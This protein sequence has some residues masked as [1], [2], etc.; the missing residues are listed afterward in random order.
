[1]EEATAT[2]QKAAALMAFQT[3][4]THNGGMLRKARGPRAFMGLYLQARVNR[5]LHPKLILY[6][7]AMDAVV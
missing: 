4:M 2:N 7:R 1:M 6:E 3:R 5:S